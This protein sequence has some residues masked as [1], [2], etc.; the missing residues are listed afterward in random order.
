MAL[1]SD[2]NREDR[3]PDEPLTRADLPELVKAVADAMKA[4]DP[5]EGTSKSAGE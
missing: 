5:G 3:T 1:V 4:Q 2:K